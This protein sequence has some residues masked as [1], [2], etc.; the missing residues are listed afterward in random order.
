MKSK[1]A[2]CVFACCKLW[3]IGTRVYIGMVSNIAVH[4]PTDVL[5]KGVWKVF[6]EVKDPTLKSLVPSLKATVLASR[7]PATTKKYLGAFM[8]WKQ[9]AEA[10]SEVVVFPVKGT[11][12]A[13]YLQYVGDT[14]GSKSAVE[15]AVHAV[16]WVHQ[17]A[18]CPSVSDLPFVQLVLDSLQRKLAKPKVR[19]EPVTADMILALV[20]SLGEAPSLA[21][22]R[23][24]AACLLAFSAFLRYDELSKLRCCDITFIPH[25]MSIHIAS[26][27]VDQ[28]RQGDSVV[29]VRT[30]SPTCPVA[31][32]E[33]YY[34]IAALPKL[35][36]LRLFRG[37]VVAKSGERLR[38]Q[39]SL[40]YTRLRELFWGK[41]A[42]LGF[43]PKQFGLHSLRS[44]GA[45]A[46]AN[47]G[48]PDRLFKRHGRWRSE[49]AK[50]GYIK[51]SMSALMSVSESLNL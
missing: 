45:S 3:L 44:G 32:L 7:A 17:L 25:R 28:Y 37:I 39:G 22:V 26:S 6:E 27:K 30:G 50:D 34:A 43:D 5:C 21:D 42:G 13:L 15:E 16:G 31:M 9:W 41:L 11:E 23:L 48:V 47:A 14:T 20:A 36:K 35:S 51:D 40:S 24:V 10:H 38:S 19:K 49:S 2:G 33:R 4:F 12:F 29:V 18:G 1:G 46:A 8:R